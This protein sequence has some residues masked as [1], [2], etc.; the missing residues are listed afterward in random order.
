[1]RRSWR[2]AQSSRL[3]RG[4]ELPR[5]ISSLILLGVLYL[6]YGYL[7]DVNTWHWL[8]DASE[9][10]AATAADA[11]SQPPKNA[12][13]PPAAGPTDEDPAQAEE[14]AQEFQAVT[15]GALTLGPEEMEPYDRLV[16]WVCNQSMERLLRRARS[17][18]LFTHFHDE[19]DKYR[20]RLVS[21]DLNVRR[22]IDAGKN[23]DGVQ[24]YEVWGFTTESR[25]RLYAA[26]VVDLPKGMPIGPS[27]HEKAKFV[28][29]F[30]KLQGYHAAGAKPGA[31]P[32]RTP[33][34]IGR[35]EW[36]PA[37]VP[38]IEDSRSWMWGVGLLA[39]LVLAVGAR[40]LY[41][42][43]RPKKHVFPTAVRDPGTGEIVAIDQWLEQSAFGEDAQDSG[44][45]A[46][47]R[48][49]EDAENAKPWK[50]D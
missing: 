9:P 7:R 38:K 26:I 29:Y 41:H 11:E 19:P 8:D 46:T 4:A 25:D 14:A 35:L 32:D 24:L 27:V 21:L 36:E 10:R 39:V 16:F 34:L 12:P 3:F 23:R 33:L 43:F 17:D 15:D 1:M 22:I 13:L 2:I 45:D 50:N 20:G 5:L 28:G 44:A 18:L 48:E 31:V 30:F 37:P 6:L 40:M 47:D 42:K 49:D